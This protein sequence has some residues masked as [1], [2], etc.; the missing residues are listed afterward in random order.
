MAL[1]EDASGASVEVGKVTLF[2]RDGLVQGLSPTIYFRQVLEQMLRI[3]YFSL[4]VVGLTAFF[5]GGALALQIYLGSSRF[6]AE[7]LVAS[8]VA[9][10]ITRELGPVMAGLMVAGRVGVA[11]RGGARRLWL[12]RAMAMGSRTVVERPPVRGNRPPDTGFGTVVPRAS[13]GRMDHDG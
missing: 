4:P 11:E 10:G 2:V 5:T 3:G 12:V 6:N 13:L 8:I 1:R 9:L 7:S